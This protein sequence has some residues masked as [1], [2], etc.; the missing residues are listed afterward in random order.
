[1]F[2]IQFPLHPLLMY[3][4]MTAKSKWLLSTGMWVED[5]IHDACETL[6]GADGLLPSFILDLSDISITVHFTEA[7]MKEM[8]SEFPVMPAPNKMLSNILQPYF[9]ARTVEELEALRPTPTPGVS[10]TS[11]HHA[12][13]SAAMCRWVNIVISNTCH[14]LLSR[15]NLLHMPQMEGWYN[16]NV[17]HQIIDVAFVPVPSI[18][19]ARG[20]SVC[21]ASSLLLN[22][23]RTCTGPENRQR[24]GPKLDGIIR[25]V[26]HDYLEFGAIEAGKD[27]YGTG[28]TKWIEDGAKLRGV[29][30]DM[31][32]RLHDMVDEESVGKLQTVGIICGG[33]KLQLVRCW[34]KKKGGAVFCQNVDRV[35]EYPKSFHE[36]HKHLWY[37]MKTVDSARRIVEETLRV[38]ER[39]GSPMTEEKFSNP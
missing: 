16:Y 27:F 34:A 20:E 37:L 36:L 24:L 18:M 2:I 13:D 6:T 3:S 28:A 31:L 1:M 22:R 21:R 9:M 17:W 4:L 23:N 10:E 38:V 26:T 19:L 15:N 11:D 14:L 30:R 12:E 32:V 29:L 39:A 25:T 7:E 8:K 35:N 33:L 5:L